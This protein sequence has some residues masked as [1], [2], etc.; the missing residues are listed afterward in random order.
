MTENGII[1]CETQADTPFLSLAPYE[2]GREYHYRRVKITLYKAR[3]LTMAGARRTYLA[4]RLPQSGRPR[5]MALRMRNC[6][7]RHGDYEISRLSGF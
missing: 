3:R 1:L 4:R 2:K 5:G 6:L 7:W